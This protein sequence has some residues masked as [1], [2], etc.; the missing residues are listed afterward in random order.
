MFFFVSLATLHVTMLDKKAVLSCHLSYS[1][2]WSYGS[3][4]YVGQCLSP[5][6]L[7]V[8]I[9]LRR[10]VLDTTLCDKDCQ[11]L[12]T[13]RWFSPGTPVSFTNKTDLRDITEILL[14]VALSTINQPTHLEYPVFTR[15]QMN[16]IFPLIYISVYIKYILL[17]DRERL[18]WVI[19]SLQA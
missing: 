16:V 10:S 7:W 2:S 8:R 4:T 3:W 5:L 13:G 9:Q 18:F 1:W 12:A 17:N 19:N 15:G 11:W 14:K 6:K